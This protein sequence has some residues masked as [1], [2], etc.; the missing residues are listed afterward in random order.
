MK[1][2]QENSMVVENKE[3]TKLSRLL[4]EMPKSRSKKPERVLIVEGIE[5]GLPFKPLVVQAEQTYLAQSQR[6]TL[7]SSLC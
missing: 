6:R 7:Q 5:G 3:A 4:N 1:G 2:E